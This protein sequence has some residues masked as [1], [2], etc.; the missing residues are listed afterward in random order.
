[1]EHYSTTESADQYT[2]NQ[3]KINIGDNLKFN[4]KVLGVLLV[5]L[6]ITMVIST[7]SAV[8]LTDEFN[9]GDFGIN[10]L[11]G[12]DFSE[13]ANISTNVMDLIV[14][15]NSGNNSNDVNSIIYFKDS[16]HN[17]NE[18]DNFIKDLE[19]NGNKVEETDKYVVLKN[20]Y[21][22]DDFDIGSNFQGI[23]DFVGSIF[24]SEGVNISS[25]NDSVSLSSNGLEVSD[26]NGENV[27]ITS[28]GVS[29]SG[30]SSSDNET[31]NVS[32]D[33]SSNIQACDYSLYLKSPSNDKVI[34][35]YGNNLELL[36]SMAETVSL[37]EN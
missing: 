16:T 8:N 5:L 17:K 30:S 37:N 33:V 6:G 24:S 9:S 23:F 28:E 21:N 13:T 20:N 2:G 27:S 4:S 14:L 34:V 26:A 3:L 15:K 7:A 25:G 32:S 12:T 18:I 10:V 29:V 22:S 1:M 19:N 11:Q 35:I 31:V 36:K